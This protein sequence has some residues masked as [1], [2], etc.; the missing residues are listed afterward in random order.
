MRRLMLVAAALALG[1]M[2][3]TV[4]SG[5]TVVLASAGASANSGGVSSAG[6]GCSKATAVQ[7]ATRLHLGNAGSITDPVGQVLC[8]AFAGS[9]SHVMVFTLTMPTAPGILGWVVFRLVGGAWQRLGPDD[10]AGVELAALGSDIRATEFVFRRGDAM[11]CP[12]G[13]TKTQLW[14]WNGTRL[15]ASA[16]KLTPPKGS[17][18]TT[19]TAASAGGPPY[20]LAAVRAGFTNGFT[21]SNP[22][23]CAGLYA[24]AFGT[25]H[26]NDFVDMLHWNGTAWAEIRNRTATCDSGDVPA[27]LRALGC[28]SG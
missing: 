10:G 6:A 3:P 9:G 24:L 7:L 15:V 23:K 8:G 2:L 22:P 1:L 27:A 12:S 14:H 11:C 18:V 26:G 4:A 28:E 5:A 16:W 21:S 13:G 17:A 19:T 20:T 25:S